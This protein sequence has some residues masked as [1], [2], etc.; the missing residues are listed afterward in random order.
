MCTD[1]STNTEAHSRTG[2][3]GEME[4]DY[5]AFCEIISNYTFFLQFKAWTSEH[6]L[7]Y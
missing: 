7:I 5:I 6:G 1:D 3:V 4:L 2:N